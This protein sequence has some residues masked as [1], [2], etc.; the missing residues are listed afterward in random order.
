[1]DCPRQLAEVLVE[2]R[3]MKTWMWISALTAFAGASVCADEAAKAAPGPLTKLIEH[4]AAHQDG[5]VVNSIDFAALKGDRSG[6]PI[7]VFDSGIGGLT[8]L[9]AILKMDA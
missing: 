3:S 1:M 7:G 4:V 2:Y 5:Q 6:L 9:E 8:V